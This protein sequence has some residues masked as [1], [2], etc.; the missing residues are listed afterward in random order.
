M[1]NEL[2]L[3]KLLMKISEYDETTYMHSIRVAKLSVGFAEFL[4]NE[5]SYGI[6]VKMLYQS[7]LVHDIGKIFIPKEILCSPNKLSN[8]EF[9]IMKNHSTN[10]YEYVMS[11]CPNVSRIILNCIKYHHLGVD[12]TGYPILEDVLT[13]EEKLYVNIITICD[14]YDALSSNR[15]YKKGF[16]L[17]KTFEIMDSM[18]KFDDILYKKF[19]ELKK[20]EVA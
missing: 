2:T 18:S 8:E 5:L 9:E 10:G 7:G 16:S 15:P 1:I 14:V 4:N 6:D 12:H 13:E 3:S 20:R 11:I 19:K 17:D